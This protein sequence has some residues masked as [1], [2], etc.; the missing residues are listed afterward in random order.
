ME[1]AKVWGLFSTVGIW[2]YMLQ[3][4]REITLKLQEIKDRK[5]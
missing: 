5:F 2:V 3:D 1:E 4:R